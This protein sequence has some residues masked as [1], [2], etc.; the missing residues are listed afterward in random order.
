MRNR[1]YAKS[2]LF[3]MEFI[4]VILFF[5]LC[6]SICISA[7][8]KADNMSRE[9]KELNHALILAQ[10]AAETIK[11]VEVG[12]VDRL[13]DITGLH[14]VKE[15]MYRGYYSKNFKIIEDSEGNISDSE[16]MIYVMEVKL[17][18]EN[19]ML[20]A[21]IMVRNKNAQNSVCELEVKKYLPEEV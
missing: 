10:S 9:S 14:K 3:L 19:K 13:S 8:V 5:A 2:Q 4:V 11:G 12:D 17:A 6:A 21:E 15:N 20:T 18:M 7:F 1:N 16:D